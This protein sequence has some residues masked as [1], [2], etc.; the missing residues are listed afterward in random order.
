MMYCEK[1]KALKGVD[2]K[3]RVYSQIGHD[4]RVTDG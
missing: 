1:A 4:R 2:A 3:L